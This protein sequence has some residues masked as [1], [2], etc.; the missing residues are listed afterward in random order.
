MILGMT[1]RDTRWKHSV[2]IQMASNCVFLTLE[3][4]ND[5]LL[6]LVGVGVNQCDH[7]QHFS[8]QSCVVLSEK[9]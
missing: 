7:H 2:E 1:Q 5:K 8:L 9:Y 4:G 6:E 3:K